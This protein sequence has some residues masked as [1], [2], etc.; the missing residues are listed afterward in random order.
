MATRAELLE[1]VG[2]RH[3]GGTRAERS[4]NRRRGSSWYKF[5]A[6]TGHHRKH[7]I[8]PLA[9]SG[10]RETEP[11][12]IP[13]YPSR[14]RRYGPEVRDGLI[15][16]WQMSDRICGKRLQP[17]PPLLLPALEK[18][19]KVGLDEAMRSKLLAVDAAGID[20]LLTE[21]RVVAGGGR[22][23]RAVSR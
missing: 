13:A 9:G 3:R 20:R 5:A 14:A 17:L 18:H 1:A 11:G 12:V 8:R 23:G 21:A 16:L 19:G 7:A 22:P 2:A 6:V 10:E 4:V 15:Q